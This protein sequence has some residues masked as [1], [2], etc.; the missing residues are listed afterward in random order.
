MIIGS[1]KRE[2]L[3]TIISIEAPNGFVPAQN[4]FYEVAQ[5]EN[6]VTSDNLEYR[7]EDTRREHE[8][9]IRMYLSH[10]V[11]IYSTKEEPKGLMRRVL[12][13]LV[14][15]ATGSNA[16]WWDLNP[17]YNVRGII[18]YNG[19]IYTFQRVRRFTF[20]IN[21]SKNFF[22]GPEQVVKEYVA[23]LQKS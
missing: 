9:H 8:D 1:E 12:P 21:T 5:I 18:H 10:F 14:G 6:K 23:S 16:E 11:G 17:N 22:V 15:I 2:K 4:G 19:G 13:V 7:S 20:F 3:E